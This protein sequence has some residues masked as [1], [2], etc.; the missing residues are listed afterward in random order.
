MNTNQ[1]IFKADYNLSSKDQIFYHYLADHFY[2]LQNLTGLVLFDRN[3]PG[4]SYKLRWTR[5]LNACTVNTL[6]L[7]TSGNVIR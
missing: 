3:I 4:K 7:S 6:Q 5:V 1:N 2:Q